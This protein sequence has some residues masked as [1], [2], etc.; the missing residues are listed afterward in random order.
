VTYDPE[1][2]II[3]E[4]ESG[5]DVSLEQSLLA[6]SGLTAEKE[7]ADYRIKLD[8]IHE[9][10]LKSLASRFPI[11][12]PPRREYTVLLRAQAL[13]D[14]LWNAKPRRCDGDVLLTDVIDGQLNPD[15]GRPVGSCVGLTSLYTVLGLREDL[16]L[17]VL[18]N[19][20]HVLN[21]VTSDGRTCNIENT[22]PLGFDWDLPDASFFAE[23]PAVMIV[24]HVLNGRGLAREK[25]NDLA[26]AEKDYTKAIRL[27]AAYATAYNNRGTIRFLRQDYGL[28]LADYERAIELDRRMVEAHFNRGLV[29]I[30]T[31]S[32]R[33]AADDFD[34]VLRIDPGYEDAQTCRAFALRKAEDPARLA[35]EQMR[36]LRA[37]HED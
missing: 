37:E 31:G 3:A 35:Q 14:Y 24:A 36:P 32:C 4:L 27:N 9:E 8:T 5:R 34:R 26:A 30:H 28:A 1:E 12:A 11:G 10:Y 2:R 23:Y 25:A 33:E 22:D 13:F 20:S 15:P 6:V 29:R 17:T 21:R 18:T 19:G 7:I 16:P